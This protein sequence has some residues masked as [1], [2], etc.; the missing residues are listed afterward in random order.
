LMRFA[1]D[2]RVLWQASFP[3][4]VLKVVGTDVL[5]G[6]PTSG[7]VELYDLR[8]MLRFAPTTPIPSAVAGIAR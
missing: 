6:A 2:G 7:N 1:P 4:E 8:R 5:I 3:G